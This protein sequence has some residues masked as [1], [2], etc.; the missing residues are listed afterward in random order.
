MGISENIPWFQYFWRVQHGIPQHT[1]FFT[2]LPKD[3]SDIL[4]CNRSDARNNLE[5]KLCILEVI[6][7]FSRDLYKKD[8]LDLCQHM[9]QQDILQ[10][11]S[12]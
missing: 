10:G 7:K 1:A 4:L 2:N 11:K 6:Y 8:R 5:C 9:S 12:N 3:S